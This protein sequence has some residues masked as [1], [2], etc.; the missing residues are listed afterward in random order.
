MEREQIL[1][2]AAALGREVKASD[3]MQ[4]YE[5]AEAAY[6]ADTKLQQ[7]IQEYSVQQRVLEEES[8]KPNPNAFLV[9]SI[10]GRLGTLY[11]EIIAEP[12]FIAFN[13]AQEKVRNLLTQINNVMMQQVTGE[14]PSACTHDCST[15]SGCH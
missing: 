3:L 8:V 10:Q 12:S 6:V 11:A 1:E 14:D 15:C 7:L 13:D 9:E 2:L 5:A 4:A